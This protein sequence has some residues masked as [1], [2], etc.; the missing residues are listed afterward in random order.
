MK[1]NYKIFFWIGIVL[2]VAAPYVSEI[3][4]S[5]RQFFDFS[6][7]ELQMLAIIPSIQLGGIVLSAWGMILFWKKEDK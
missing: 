1:A 3:I 2:V 5:F 6:W 7:N 4:F